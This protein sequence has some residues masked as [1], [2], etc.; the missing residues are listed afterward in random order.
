MRYLKELLQRRRKDPDSH[1]ACLIQMLIALFVITTMYSP[2]HS[3][4]KYFLVT[5]NNTSVLDG[6]NVQRYSRR[7]G[8]IIQPSSKAHTSFKIAESFRALR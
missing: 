1:N 4:F 2:T 3:F 5:Y 6:R 7:N 8:R